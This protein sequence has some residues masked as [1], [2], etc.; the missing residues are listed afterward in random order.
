MAS[1]YA[2]STGRRLHSLGGSWIAPGF[3]PFDM[4][5]L[6]GPNESK[7]VTM[8]ARRP[9]RRDATV[10]TVVIPITMPRMVRPERNRCVQTADIA[11]VMFSLGEMF[12]YL[13]GP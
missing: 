12:I 4:K 5:M 1:A 6:S 8:P 2:G 13:F 11:I 3:W 9:V 7:N 10:T